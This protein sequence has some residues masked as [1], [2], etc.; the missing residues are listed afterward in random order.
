MTDLTE[1]PPFPNGS[2]LDSKFNGATP[3]VDEKSDTHNVTNGKEQKE[4]VIDAGL[5]GEDHCMIVKHLSR[6]SKSKR[7]AHVEHRRKKYTYL[8]ASR[9]SC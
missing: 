2:S 8:L 1:F 5:R 7:K 6:I 4:A 3:E 9:G